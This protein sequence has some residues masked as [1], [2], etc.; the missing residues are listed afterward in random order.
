MKRIDYP[1]SYLSAVIASAAKRSS[2]MGRLLDRFVALLLAMTGARVALL[3][4]ACLSI[5][6]PLRA[7]P[8]SFDQLRR[9]DGARIVPDKFLRSYDPITIF[10]DRD[11]GPKAGGP[12]D[13]HERFAKLSAEPAGEWRWIGARA[14][15]FRPAEPWKPL[16]RVDVEAGA[17]ATRLVALL[18]TPASTNPAEG[19]D[20]IADLEQITL[21]FPEPVD[22]AALTRLLS[23]E[24]RPAPGIS[25]LGGQLLT[26]K[27]YDIRPLERADRSAAQSVAI[28]L[29]ERLR[30][31]RVALL[32]LKLADEPGLDDEIFELR[33]RSAAPFAVTEASCGR[34]WSDDKQDGVLRCA[35][36]YAVA[37]SSVASSE[38]EEE[39]APVANYQPANR[40]RL[41]L[42][43]TEQPDEI[44]ILRAREALRISPPVDDLLVEIDRKRLDVYGKFLSDRAYE[45]VL[46]P[47]ALRDIRKRALASRFSLRFAFDRDRPALAWDAAQGLVERFGPQ[48]LPLR[49][50]GYDRADIRIHA[51]DPLARDFWPFPKSGVETDDAAAPPLP[52]NEPAHWGETDA[53]EAAAIAERIKALGSPAVSAL[54]DLPIRRNGADAKFGLDLSSQLA[55]IAGAG[56]P[57]T[58]LVGLRAV[59]EKKRHWLRAQVTDLTLSAIEERARVRFTVTSLSTAQ[60]V[61][62]AEVRLE[63]VKGEK[64][65]TLARG[66]TDNSGF[67]VFDPGKRAEADV[68]RIVVTKGLDTLVIDANDGPSEYARENWTKPD[69][70]WLAW[71]ADPEAPRKE[72][73]RTLCH[74]FAERPIYRPEEAVHIKGFVRAYRDGALSIAKRGGTLVVSGP[75]NQEWRIPVKLD[76]SGSFYHK[77]DAQTPATGDYSL[78]F[79]PDGA[80]PKK[81]EKG[82]DAEA[83]S[84]GEAQ[85][86]S[87]GQFP[88]KKEAY[89]LPTF[90]VVL[91]AP[92]IVPLDGEFNVDLVARYFAGGLVSERPV[93]WRAVQFPHMFQPPGREGFLFSTDARFS[94]EGKF[95]SSPVLERDART[96][97]G[98]ASRM[99]F[100]TTIEPT[101]QPR[102]YSIEATVTGDDGVEVRNVHNVIAVPPFVLGVKVPRYVERPGVVTPEFLALDGRGETVEGLSVTMRFIRRNWVSTL[103]ASDFAQGAAKYVT[104]V[105]D[106]TIVERKL[107]SGKEA[108]GIELEAREA[109][110]Y[111]VQLE[112]YDRIGRRQQMSV[113]FF[114]GGN[115]PVTFQRPPASTATITADKQSYAPG[116][117]A[118]L[119]VQSP[120][121]NAKAL[122]IVEQPNGAFDY[123]FIDIANGFGR[124]ALDLR[125]EQTPK[126]AVHFLIMRGRLKDSAPAPASNID[127]GKPV[128]IAAT[129]WIEVTPVENIVTAKLDYPA[130]A[131]PGQEVEV[132]LRLFDHLGKPLSGEATFWMVDQAVL[133]LAKERPLDPLPDFIVERETKLAARDTRN[134][135]FGKIPLEEIPGGDAGLDEWGAETNVSVRKN[136]TPVPIYLPSVKIGADGLAKIKVKLPD[137]LTVFKLRAKAVSGADRFGYATGE[138]LIRQ[139]L[140]AQPVLPRFVRPGDALD[141]SVIARVVEGPGGGGRVSIA[142]EGLSL[143]SHA[144]QAFA[145]MQNKPARIDVAA[146]APEPAPGTESVKLNFRVERDADRARDAV[147]IELPIRPDRL[148]VRRYEIVE[149]APGESKTLAAAS[150]EARQGSFR[151]DVTLAG[152]P[153]LVKLIAGLNALVEYPYGCT[154]QRLSLARAALALKSFTPILSA[155]GLEKRLS[156]DVRN[157][158]RAIDQSV[159]ADGLVAFWPRSR[160]NV[161]L[162]AWAYSFLASAERAGEPIDKP[163]ADR[164]ANVLKLSLRSDYPRLLSGEELRERVEALIALAEGGKLD[165]SYVAEL[166]R[167]ADFMPNASVAELTRAAARA[168]A[169]DRRIVDSLLDSL[170]SRVTI[171]SR[172]GAQYYAG[173]AADGGNPAILP[174]ETRALA[175]MV[176]AV[177]VASPSDP[178]AGLLRDALLRLGEGDGW[179]STNATAAAIDALAEIWRRPQSPLPVAFSQD[180]AGE[181]TATLDA[182]APMLRKTSDA[183]SALT[184]ANR[185]TAPLIALVETRYEPKESGARAAPVSE[186]FALTRDILRVGTAD[187]PLEKVAAENGVVKLALGDVIEETAE[188]VN[189]QDRTHVA[190]SLPLPAGFE[191]LNPNL[192]TAPTEARPSFAPTLAPTSVSFGDDRMFYAY[193]QLPK[194]TYRFAFR[195]KAQTAGAFTEP[196]GV[197]ETMYKKGVQAQSAGRRVEIAK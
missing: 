29:R 117:T 157:T 80:Q 168:R 138:M 197:V 144:P 189:P 86:V 54:L 159:D 43:F 88:F 38:G 125:K 113:D 28:R 82:A 70:A 162:T 11:A 20:P 32:R 127:Q 25:P 33:A 196:P 186:G 15:Q 174:S 37:A 107:T 39:S 81:D 44:D 102:R 69:G 90:E 83:E 93:R 50:R 66:I 16:Q 48:L 99:T 146:H 68:R 56:Q 116:E 133:S 169:G 118:T 115:T 12:E 119:I 6:A 152:D 129:K 141:V 111:V 17:A 130:K 131:R 192:A 194:G 182:N 172:N 10:F 155:A 67:F 139:E 42:S 95:K 97:A 188:L 156:G 150:D 85:T 77:F 24:L 120:F 65:V 161:S 195:A 94:G 49:G 64:F 103:Q 23:I 167:H 137:T 114:V 92:Q 184:I 142:A 154:E 7:E 147:E 165:E 84:E 123:Q 78:R 149:I 5:C 75:S 153:A 91:N 2:A 140:I 9:A 176:R 57:G 121:Q 163:L 74:V 27:D 109:G 143:A 98:G 46:A 1:F 173:Q 30:D 128:T 3:L 181:E 110:V 31:G 41:T 178:R 135:A 60:P 52:G 63:G 62:G 179:G 100:D 45:L 145:W 151:R 187:A 34:G 136:F 18:P 132:A 51:I 14:L 112:A 164:L 89:R 21:T 124:Y 101:A 108:R 183:P 106:D 185:G 134:L 40:R 72:E 87:C 26:P 126:L 160:G 47:G 35:F 180:G 148:P 53:P 122:A 76:A 59:D 22:I 175:E 79:E 158:I 96:D 73:P 104:Q 190:I 8:A 13:A 58:Y 193:D 105:I 191:P 4:L 19:A 55:K 36:G 170:W 71:T 171:L 177:A 166:S 61:A